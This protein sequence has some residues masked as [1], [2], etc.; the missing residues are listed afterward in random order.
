MFGAARTLPTWSN[1]PHAHAPPKK[2][3]KHLSGE[4]VFRGRRSLEVSGEPDA[5][6]AATLAKELKLLCNYTI[7]LYFLLCYSTA[8]LYSLIY[9]STT[10]LCLLL[11][12]YTTMLTTILTTLLLYVLLYYFTTILTTALLYYCTTLSNQ[13]RAL[14]HPITLL[15]YYCT[16]LHWYFYSTVP[17]SNPPRVL[18]QPGASGQCL[19]SRPDAR[20]EHPAAAARPAQAAHA[21]PMRNLSLHF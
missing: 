7:R 18:P 4:A 11:Y 3:L 9:H 19:R 2:A 20:A 14:S 15:L 6:L 5:G 10:L 12:Y 8:L 21:G 1:A 16:A 17:L 13:P